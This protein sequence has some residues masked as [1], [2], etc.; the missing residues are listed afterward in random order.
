MTGTVEDAAVIGL[1]AAVVISPWIYWLATVRRNTQ[2]GLLD[3]QGLL[4]RL[5]AQ[6][7]FYARRIPDALSGPFV[8]VA[9]V[10]SRS[11]VVG[12][13]ATAGAVIASGVILVGLIRSVR[14]P[15][16]R[17]AGL[18]PLVTLPILLVWPF[19]EAGRFLIPLVPCLLV[20]AVEGLAWLLG[21]FLRPTPHPNP[22]PQGGRGPED[23]PP[24]ERIG[25]RGK[26]RGPRRSSALLILL[27]AL[28][29]PAY[30]LLTRRAEA[31]RRS[32]TDFDA[33]C[34][35][36]AREARQPGPVLT[37]HPGEVFWQ[38][39]REVVY[40]APGAPEALF[41]QIQD[42]KI[43]YILVDSDR[44]ANAPPTP[45]AR[46]VEGRPGAVRLAFPGP[47]AV[48]EVR[49]DSGP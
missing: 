32:H 17:L 43:A 30:A 14:D 9:T 20:G 42:Q 16:R 35:W 4:P 15:R 12:V 34:G 46:L 21:L 1:V 24:R 5:A 36:I 49:R 23:G 11:R 25:W 38:T 28:P 48:Y 22:P 18:V 2:V 10:F 7:L 13:V 3:A 39:G 31:Q 29:Y 47:V 6:V 41:R 40:P 37:R 27:V 19:T 26:R 44:F 8:E 45:L 33:A